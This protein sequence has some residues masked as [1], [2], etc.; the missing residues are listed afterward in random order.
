MFK[1]SQRK[2]LKI[3]LA[4]VGP[5]GSGKT[6]TALQFAQVLAEGQG[7]AVIDTE[8]SSADRYADIVGFDACQ[9]AKYSPEAYTEA[10]V[11]AGK[12]GYRVLVIDS[13]SHAWEGQDGLLERVDAIAKRS[14]N[15]S[16]VAWKDATPLHRRL[17]DTMLAYPGHLIVTMRAKMEY[18]QEKDSEGRT[19][20]RKIGLAPVQRQGIEFEFDLVGDLD[21]EHILTITKSRAVDL[22]GLVSHKPGRAVAEQMLAWANGGTAVDSKPLCPVCGLPGTGEAKPAKDGS[23]AMRCSTPDCQSEISGWFKVV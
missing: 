6:Y 7:I 21:Q 3:R 23:P 15:N 14:K 16:Y 11:A 9:L 13:L 4:L 12:A 22:D 5:T 2:N 20:I 8:R 19:Q 18:I 10:I 17:V 1:R